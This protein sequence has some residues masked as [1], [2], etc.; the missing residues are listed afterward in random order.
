M[1]DASGKRTDSFHLVCLLQA[2][3]QEALILFGLHAFGH[4]GDEI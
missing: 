3:L 2:F 1:G 4:V